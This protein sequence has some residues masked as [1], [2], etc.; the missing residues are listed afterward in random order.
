MAEHYAR[1]PERRAETRD[2][3]NPPNAVVEPEL[4]KTPVF[5]V[6]GMWYYLGPLALM[7]LVV[8][9]AL[10]FLAGR[11]DGDDEGAVP[12]TG[13]EQEAPSHQPMRY[14]AA[15][16]AACTATV[17]PAI[18]GSHRSIA[19]ASPCH[20][21]CSGTG[22]DWSDAI[23]AWG[24]STPGRPFRCGSTQA[25]SSGRVRIGRFGAGFGGAVTSGAS[26]M[27]SGAP[28]SRETPS[29]HCPTSPSIHI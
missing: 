17:A 12:T 2:P 10:I 14:A 8:V 23:V 26:S 29:G 5:A 19:P 13:I 6:A 24:T 28:S 1:D 9:F 7:V 18:S 27:G 3:D 25:T 20:A 11:D 21:A 4:R 15:A 22:C 16:A